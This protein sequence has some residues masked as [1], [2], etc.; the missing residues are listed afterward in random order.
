MKDKIIIISLFLEQ[1]GKEIFFMIHSRGSDYF[2]PSFNNIDKE[3]NEIFV[4]FSLI[5]MS[6]VHYCAYLHKRKRG[7]ILCKYQFS[8]IFNNYICLN[9]RRQ[10]TFL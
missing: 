5:D 6:L 10:Q 3:N 1:K 2:L 8:I 9:R 4:R 7:K